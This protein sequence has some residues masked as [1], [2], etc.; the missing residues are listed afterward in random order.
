MKGRA[1]DLKNKPNTFIYGMWSKTFTFVYMCYLFQQLKDKC[2]SISNHLQI[3]GSF[4]RAVRDECESV[5]K[6]LE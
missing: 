1:F 4:V 5:L 6:N 2:Y 3:V